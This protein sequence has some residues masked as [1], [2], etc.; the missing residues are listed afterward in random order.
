MSPYERL[1]ELS[2]AQLELVLAGRFAEVHEVAAAYGDLVAA[3]PDRPPRDAAPLLVEAESS[4]R[5]AIGATLAAME[6]AQTALAR[7]AEGR[8]ALDSYAPARRARVVERR[9]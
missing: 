9:A 8:R 7:L 1:L 5:T 6:A 3:L 2:R 4:V